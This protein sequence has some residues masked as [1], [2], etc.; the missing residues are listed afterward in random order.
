LVGMLSSSDVMTDVLGIVR[1]AL[2]ESS[3][4]NSSEEEEGNDHLAP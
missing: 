3:S 1:A 2:P 4:T